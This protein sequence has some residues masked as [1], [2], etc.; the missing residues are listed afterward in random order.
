MT[1]AATSSNVNFAVIRKKVNF[2]D[3]SFTAETQSL[4]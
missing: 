4:S 2:G 1:C 3:V